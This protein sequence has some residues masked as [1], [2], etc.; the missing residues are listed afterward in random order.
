MTELSDIGAIHFVRGVHFSKVLFL[1]SN[2]HISPI[3]MHILKQ[4]QER[5]TSSSVQSDMKFIWRVIQHIWYIAVIFVNDL[6]KQAIQHLSKEMNEP[7]V[8][9]FTIKW[10]LNQIK[11]YQ[12]KE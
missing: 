11:H 6:K 4:L 7:N 5:N 1:T 3:R 12:T 8:W 9:L 10:K 2:K